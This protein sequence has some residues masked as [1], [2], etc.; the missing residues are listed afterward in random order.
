MGSSEE[1]IQ[2]A[3]R[4]G[5]S[6]KGSWEPVPPA[7]QSLSY[8]HASEHLAIFKFS[9]IFSLGYHLDECHLQKSKKSSITCRSAIL[10]LAQ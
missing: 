3:G 10:H 6:F 4:G 9:A 7:M 8:V 1:K 2:G 5:V